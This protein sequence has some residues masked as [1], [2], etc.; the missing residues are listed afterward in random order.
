MKLFVNC[1]LLTC[2][3]WILTV[4]W[5]NK[6]V[7]VSTGF[8]RTCTIL[9]LVTVDTYRQWRFWSGEK[10][11]FLSDWENKNKF[12]DHKL[13]TKKTAIPLVWT[14]WGKAACASLSPKQCL[15]PCSGTTPV[16]LDM[17]M[18]HDQ[19]VKKA[20]VNLPIRLKRIPNTL[21]IICWVH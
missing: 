6:F 14:V 10:Y 7:L 16:Y 3:E 20:I 17:R 9:G 4:I 13:Q 19:P 8:A 18:P 5:A 2:F 11:R 15:S 21:P 1:C 12:V